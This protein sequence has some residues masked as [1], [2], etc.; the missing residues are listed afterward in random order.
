[1]GPKLTVKIPTGI[2]IVKAQAE[3]SRMTARPMPKSYITTGNEVPFSLSVLSEVTCAIR[4]IHINAG[5]H[6]VDRCSTSAVCRQSFFSQESRFTKEERVK[7]NRT[8]QTGPLHPPVKAS[9]QPTSSLVHA[10]RHAC[11]A[12]TARTARS[13][14]FAYDTRCK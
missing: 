5:A 13:R 4:H 3:V 11:G 7:S 6:D 1:M 8:C 10:G 9:Q 12:A 14:L 2:G